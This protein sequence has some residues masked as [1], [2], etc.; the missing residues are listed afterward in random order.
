MIGSGLSGSGSVKWALRA[1]KGF[2]RLRVV[3]LAG[4]VDSRGTFRGQG[5]PTPEAR[6]CCIELHE[7]NTIYDVAIIITIVNLLLTCWGE[8]LIF[9]PASLHPRHKNARCPLTRILD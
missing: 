3:P 9:A 4:F 1:W 6:S 2:S 7:Q 8:W 5:L